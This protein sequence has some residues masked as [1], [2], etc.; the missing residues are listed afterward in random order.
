MAPEKPHDGFL[1][2]IEAKIAA[3]K[4]VA[5]SYRAA[6]AGDGPLS[7]PAV[8]HAVGAAAGA[9]HVHGHAMQLPVGVFRDKGL[10]EAIAIYLGAGRRKQTNKEI[11]TGLQGGGFPTTADSFEATVATALYRLK[12]DGTILRF[13]DGW[14]LAASY[15]DNLRNRLE[16]DANPKKTRKK[17]REKKWK[18]NEAKRARR[19]KNTKDAAP[20]AEKLPVDNLDGRIAKFLTQRPGQD[21][22]PKQIAEA[23]G[24]TYDKAFLMAFARLS[25][26]SK[27]TRTDNGLYRAASRV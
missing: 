19:T 21:F 5:D 18:V 4:A 13:P 2:A 12:K 23:L 20:K 7:E 26:F 9:S 3:W 25:R 14:D 10:K 11:A 15:P 1:A 17:Q 6:V 27:V 24:E 8:V 16:K 22:A